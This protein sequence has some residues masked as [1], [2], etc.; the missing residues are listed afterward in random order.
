M[1][2][3]EEFEQLTVALQAMPT[4]KIDDIPHIPFRN[5]MVVLSKWYKEEG[6]KIPDLP[7]VGDGS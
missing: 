7:L 6:P 4:I 2:N 5:V 3:R 1:L